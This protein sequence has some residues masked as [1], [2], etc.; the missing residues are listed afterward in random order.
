MSK[1]RAKIAWWQVNWSFEP[2]FNHKNKTQ[3]R[4]VRKGVRRRRDRETARL[5]E[6]QR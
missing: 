5:I 6:E 3:R 4:L 1:T 2:S